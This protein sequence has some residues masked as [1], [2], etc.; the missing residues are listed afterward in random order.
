MEPAD[1]LVKGVDWFNTPSG[2][3]NYR[4]PGKERRSSMMQLIM[5][6]MIRSMSKEERAEMMLNMMPQMMK[7]VDL[8]KMAPNLI[9]ELGELLTLNAL[10]RFSSRVA[11]SRELR[12]ALN[13]LTDTMQ[14]KM[15]EMMEMMA[16]LLR[17]VMPRVMP[18]MLPVMAGM[19]SEM[20]KRGGCFMVDVV[21]Q[22]PEMATHVGGM[23]FEMAPRM[24]GK[25]IPKKK[26]QTFL[27]KMERAIGD[28]RGA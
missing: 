12:E 8:K 18:R 3:Q 22:N 23:M 1:R 21:D 10:Y 13:R 28:R 17:G 25:V 14:T 15:P 24:A 7:H 27:D 9:R 20:N 19:M 2:L 4:G 11:R 26:R 6:K 16:P 5:T